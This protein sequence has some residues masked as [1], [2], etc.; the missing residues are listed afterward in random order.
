M[1][2]PEPPSGWRGERFL[3]G[4]AA[5]HG[6]NA[7]AWWAGVCPWEAI[8]DRNYDA[9]EQRWPGA[10]ARQSMLPP[11]RPPPLPALARAAAATCGCHLPRDLARRH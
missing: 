9:V 5:C 6:R 4:E 8:D 1:P 2:A 3:R 11:G 10:A 7:R